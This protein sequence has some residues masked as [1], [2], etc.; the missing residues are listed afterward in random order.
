MEIPTHLLKLVH[1]PTKWNDTHE[2]FQFGL[3]EFLWGLYAAP[4]IWSPPLP[5]DVSDQIVSLEK[6]TGNRNIVSFDLVVD[7]MKVALMVN[8]MLHIPNAI[9]G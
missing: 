9:N 1:H 2:S 6:F 4:H 5:H 8:R 3:W 7:V